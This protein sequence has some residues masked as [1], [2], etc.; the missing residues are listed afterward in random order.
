MRM[1]LLRRANPEGCCCV[2]G[3]G[4]PALEDGPRPTAKLMSPLEG[5][6]LRSPKE[7]LLNG[8]LRAWLLLDPRQDWPSSWATHVSESFK[9]RV[10]IAPRRWVR[11]LP[12]AEIWLVS[13]GLMRSG[14]WCLGT[15]TRWTLARPLE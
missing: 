4:Q 7:L 13:V 15:L 9:S 6:R 2:Q 10:K 3:R 14:L 12:P 1:R 11:H 5:L 8:L